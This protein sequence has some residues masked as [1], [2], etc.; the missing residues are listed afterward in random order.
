MEIRQVIKG[1]FVIILVAFAVFLL[2]QPSGRLMAKKPPEPSL[3]HIWSME[4]D[5]FLL[6]EQSLSPDGTKLLGIHI[7]MST[8]QNVAYKDLTTGKFEFI[9]N[10]DWQSEGQGFTYYPVWSPDGTEVAFNFCGWNSA[11]WELRVADIKGKSRTIYRCESKD[12]GKIFPCKWFPESDAILAIRITSDNR[13]LLGVV[14][15]QDGDF[16]LIFETD[17]PADA[18]PRQ[19]SR[20]Y[21]QVDL[22]PDGRHIVFH[23]AEGDEKNLYILD[24]A[25]KTVKVL[26]DTP[27]RDSHPLWSPD[28]R[29][30]AFLSNRGKGQAL[31][32][33]PVD[34]EGNP[35]GEPY[36]IRDSMEHAELSNWTANGIA[37][38]NLV[39]IRNIYTLAVDP[40]S[41]APAGKPTQLDFLPTGSNSNPIYSPDGK[42]I[43]FVMKPPEE[44]PVRKIVIYPVSGGEARDFQIPNK[45]FW[46]ALSGLR[47]L[48]DGSGISFCGEA[49][50]E[51][52]GWKEGMRGYRLFHL[53]LETGE[54]Q[55]LTLDGEGWKRSEWRGDGQGYYY[56]RSMSEGKFDIAEK[57]IQTGDERVLCGIGPGLYTLRC[58]RDYTKLAFSLDFS[59]N[60]RGIE[61]IDTKTGKKLKEFKE[62]QLS[63]WSPD[64]RYILA[65]KGSKPSYHVISCADSSS[66]EY[67]LSENLPQGDRWHFD[68]SPLGDQVAFA[69]RLSQF[70]AYII[71]NAIPAEKK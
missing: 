21:F 44:P 42:F 15:V 35:E 59:S 58:S 11:V 2:G 56:N 54:W 53:D 13:L 66:R 18:N 45:N 27:A 71:R 12:E 19:D 69:F 24:I 4:D 61:I 46:A 1:L 67:D 68:W 47:W 33:V 32:T 7:S 62:F 3:T 17:I 31:W 40:Q 63:A 22:S 26:T 48:P 14:S 9:T 55:T 70:D 30:I 5:N 52:P 41:G 60:L 49:S 37:Y 29:H 57:D 38:S 10:F 8:G 16:N 34:K 20:P 50:H 36:L 43:A 25:S 39:S 23:K 51:T 65:R 28:G 64:G 6:E